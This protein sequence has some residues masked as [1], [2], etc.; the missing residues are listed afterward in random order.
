MPFVLD[1][2]RLSCAIL[3]I[4]FWRVQPA[5]LAELTLAGPA[6]FQVRKLQTPDGSVANL[7]A[8]GTNTTLQSQCEPRPVS[9]C[10]KSMP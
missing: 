6:N 3:D 5:V 8:H 1:F 4:R 7:E 2:R 9:V 10:H